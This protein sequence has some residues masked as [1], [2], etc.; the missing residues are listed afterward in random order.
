[1]N[2]WPSAGL[3][4]RALHPLPHPSR[5]YG[6]ISFPKSFSE[7]TSRFFAAG[8]QREDQAV[9]KRFQAFLYFC[10]TNPYLHSKKKKKKTNSRWFLILWILYSSMQSNAQR[11]TW[12][13]SLIGV[14]AILVSCTVFA[15]RCVTSLLKLYTNVQ[16]LQ[17]M[18]VSKSP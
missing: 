12:S 14:K 7:L 2:G 15:P 17:S 9:E 18:I 10:S 5:L 6:M 13:R 8:A 3:A 1:M 11:L 4:S 16:S